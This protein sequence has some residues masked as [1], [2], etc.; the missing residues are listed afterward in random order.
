MAT[1]RSASKK[2]A[3]YESLKNLN[4]NNA[5]F[6]HWLVC[7]RKPEAV[8]VQFTNS[9]SSQQEKGSRFQCVLTSG[10]EEEY[11]I[12]VIGFQWKNHWQVC[13]RNVGCNALSKFTDG[14]IW[15]MSTPAFDDKQKMEWISTP[16]KQVVLM[17]SP[18]E[19]KLLDGHEEDEAKKRR[20]R[21]G[22][23]EFH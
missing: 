23:F 11:C 22:G 7:V 16:V 6:A 8:P 14:S 21:P 19:F 9:R 18:T 3:K 17:C 12:G 10:I 5:K 2:V 13:N 1:R 15:Q 20:G 4:H